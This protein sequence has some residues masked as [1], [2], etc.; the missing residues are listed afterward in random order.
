MMKSKRLILVIVVGLGIAGFFVWNGYYRDNPLRTYQAAERR[1]IE[2]MTADTY[3]GKTPQET[4][5]LFVI[6]LRAGD[7]DL[8]SKYFLLDEN[9]SREKWVTNLSTIQNQ[10]RLRQLAELISKAVP[11][12][13]DSI[14]TND[15]KY[16][17]KNPDGVIEATINF[18]LNKYSEIW[19]IESI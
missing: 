7:V 15:F 19:K 8:A 17:L 11:N 9:A 13:K 18:E 5:D 2:A 4:L 3:G 14:D 1:Y 16:V 6:A 10:K 12:P